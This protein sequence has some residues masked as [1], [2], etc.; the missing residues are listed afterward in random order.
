MPCKDTTS[1]MSIHL[2]ENNC[3]VDF[4]FSK[5]TCS[6][7]IGGDTGF[8]DYCKGKTAEEILNLEFNELLVF[9]AFEADE[10]QFF[11]YMEWEAL[12]AA[13]AQLLGIAINN[14]RYQISSINYDEN[15]TTIRQIMV[16]LKEMPKIVSCLKREKNSSK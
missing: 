6:K 12:Q 8:L 13:I 7:E 14:K 1:E 10:D 11:L 16:P 5:I 9:F 3:L 4:A 2:N 15:G